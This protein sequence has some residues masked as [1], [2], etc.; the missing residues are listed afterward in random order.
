MPSCTWYLEQLKAVS[1][2]NCPSW[3]F[4]LT[5]PPLVPGCRCSLLD[6]LHMGHMLCFIFL[7]PHTSVCSSR[8]ECD[9]RV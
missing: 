3:S 7:M 6:G 1:T 8:L 2:A 9:L 4:V 5:S